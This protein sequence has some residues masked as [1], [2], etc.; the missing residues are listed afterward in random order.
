MV[1][2]KITLKGKT[3]G[4]IALAGEE[5]SRLLGEGYLCGRN[6]NDTG[7]FHFD[8]SGEEEPDEESAAA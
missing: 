4:D 5:V 8:V 6:S 7:S 3:H 1:T 2:V